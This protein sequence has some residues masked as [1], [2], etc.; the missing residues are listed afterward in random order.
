[1]TTTLLIPKPVPSNGIDLALC[2]RLA[3]EAC[4]RA[5]AAESWA[6]LV[7][8]RLNRQQCALD[9]ARE[10]VD[11]PRK[12]RPSWVSL[13]PRSCTSC[14]Q[15]EV[16]EMRE[17]TPSCEQSCSGVEAK[18]DISMSTTTL[19]IVIVVLLLLFGGGFYG[20]GRW[21]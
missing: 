4:R 14:S 16:A 1:M 7:F 3:Q 15:V 6:T 21:Y 5:S 13:R 8:G 12:T 17:G 2:K 9:F 10:L 18:G 20:R 11:L 19:L